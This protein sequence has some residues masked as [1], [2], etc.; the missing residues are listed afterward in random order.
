MKYKA[1]SLLFVVAMIL[2]VSCTGL[3]EIPTSMSSD[4]RS[5]VAQVAQVQNTEALAKQRQY[6]DS[7]D[8]LIASAIEALTSINE[9]DPYAACFSEVRAFYAMYGIIVQSNATI[10]NRS[11]GVLAIPAGI[12]ATGWSFAE[13]AKQAGD[14][15]NFETSN[16]DVM[17]NSANEAPGNIMNRVGDSDN[18]ETP[19]VF[20]PDTLITIIPE[21]EGTPL[22]DV[23][24]D[25][26]ID[27][28]D[29]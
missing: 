5:C 2:L 15:T 11:L 18:L 23:D 26:D 3:P 8:A 28:P 17:L 6:V 16:S 22:P 4:A 9:T 7:S 20:P 25:I 12:V 27:R 29:E 13:V 21:P 1:L 14:V 10:V 19:E 24:I